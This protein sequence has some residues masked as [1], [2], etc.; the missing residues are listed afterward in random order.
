[1]RGISKIAWRGF[2]RRKARYALTALGIVL[3]VAN[4]F[5]VLVINATTNRATSA[6]VAEQVGEVSVR[7]TSAQQPISAADVTR[8]AHLPGVRRAAA[9][10]PAFALRLPTAKRP[11]AYLYTLNRAA[12]DAGPRPHLTHGRWFRPGSAEIDLSEHSAQMLHK[13]V[14]DLVDVASARAQFGTVASVRGRLGPFR[15]VGTFRPL[16]GDESGDTVSYGS[17]DYVWANSGHPT[18]Q[19]VYLKLSSRTDPLLF[20]GQHQGDSPSFRFDTVG[21]PPEFRQF[22]SVLQGAMSG[23]AAIAVFVGAF[24]IYLTFSMS[25]VERTRMLG[26]LHAIGSTGRQVR[27]LVLT[28]AVALGGIATLGG[29]VLGYGLARV[30]APVASRIVMVQLAQLAVTPSAVIAAVAVGLVA[31]LAGSVVPALRAGRL[32]PVE[33]IRGP[34]SAA[35]RAS[36]AWIAGIPLIAIGVGVATAKRGISAPN[37]FDQVASLSLLLGSVLL[38]PPI[39]GPLARTARALTRRRSRGLGGVAV[40]HVVRERSQSAYTLGLVMVVLAMMLSLGAANISV[41]REIDRWIDKRFGASLVAY[42]QGIRPVAFER[43]ARVHGVADVSGAFFS[44]GDIVRPASAPVNLIFVRDTW[45]SLAGFPW[46]DGTDTEGERIITHADELLL[47]SNLAHALGVRRG[48]TVTLSARNG[49]HR[50]RVAA[51]YTSWGQNQEVGAVL[52]MRAAPSFFATAPPANVMYINFT[53]NAPFVATRAAVDRALAT[54]VADP[55]RHPPPFGPNGGIG[56]S[57]YFFI[58]GLQ[59]KAQAR[60][61]TNS[62][63]GL[64]YVVLLIPVVVGLLGLANTMA[65]SVLR[66]FREIGVVQAVGAEPKHVRRMVVGETFMLVAVAFVLSLALGTVMS[67]LIVRGIGAFEGSSVAYVFPWTWVPALAVL[68]IVIALIAAAAPARR[69]SRLTPV[70]ALRYE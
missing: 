66:R 6:G 56:R 19:S 58:S 65:T 11:G 13:H 64:F 49:P 29:L 21:P 59:I 70:E 9:Y 10:G 23:A 24:L 7:P 62:Y 43:V 67:R 14:G 44:Q 53:K 18:A 68:S 17:L 4:I 45:F 1:V 50:F 40:M 54:T 16:T 51:I 39:V 37:V 60:R 5:G 33:A 20:V 35:P 25:V 31:T 26:T 61:Q 63:F 12:F 47:P 46:S 22:I 57:R 36:R 30:L 28:E 55:I 15:V 42:Q 2:T 32:S 41:G 69:A 8:I 48:G 52:G 38:L 3:G 27:R 34:H